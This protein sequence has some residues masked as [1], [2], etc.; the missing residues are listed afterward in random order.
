MISIGRLVNYKGYKYALKALSELDFNFEYL[1]IGNGPLYKS[2]NKY[3]SRLKLTNKV[4]IICGLSDQEKYQ[5]LKESHL[6]M[7]P[8][9]NKAEAYGVVQIEAM[10]F[11]LPIINTDL[12]N[13]VNYLMPS[14]N[15][16]TVPTKSCSALK[17]ALLK[18]KND[19]IIFN[20][21]NKK[22][23]ERYVSLSEINVKERIDSIFNGEL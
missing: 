11:S 19:K 15:C 22:S 5:Y 12:K 9:C 6:F 4:K 14:S 1:I 17:E 10:A 18:I 23:Y 21:L 16:L 7:F 20:K 13:G 8:S 3:I 2:L